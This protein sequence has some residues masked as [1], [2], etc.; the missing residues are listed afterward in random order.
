MKELLVT[1]TDEHRLE[2]TAQA[3]A[4][5][6]GEQ[7]KKETIQSTITAFLGIAFVV[8]ILALIALIPIK[9]DVPILVTYSAPM[10]E[11]EPKIEKKELSNNVQPRPPG[12]SSSM[13]RVIASS[14]PSEVSVPLPEITVPDAMI[15]MEDDFGV[16]FGS[17]EGDGSGGGGA[18]FFGGKVRGQRIVYIVDFS[19]SMTGSSG[20]G[21]RIAALKKELE[22]SIGDLKGS[23]EVSLVFFSSTAWTFDT[24]GAN[25]HE[26]GWSGVGKMPVVPWYPATSKVKQEL[27]SKLRSMKTGGGTTWYPPLKMALNMNPPPQGVFLLSDGA[28]RDADLVLEELKELN[29]NRVPINTIALELPGSPAGQLMEIAEKSGGKFSMV[30]KGKLYKGSS[31][32]KFTHGKYD[33]E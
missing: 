6:V 17:D 24:I 1:E 18:T 22:K 33:D 10:E 20:G 21:S 26:M 25:P 30:Y 2:E 12:A 14:V 32:E 8:A 23:M 4:R 27:L 7:R 13:A 15:G 31:A 19:G 11:E 28:P 3:V 29:P 5:V 9:K 16:G